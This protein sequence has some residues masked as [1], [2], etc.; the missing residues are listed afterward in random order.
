[1]YQLQH[2]RVSG[3]W[4]NFF[5]VS[6]PYFAVFGTLKQIVIPDDNNA[7]YCRPTLVL[8]RDVPRITNLQG[9]VQRVIVNGEVFEKLMESHSEQLNVAV[10]RGPPC[11]HMPTTHSSSSSSIS[12]SSD[13]L[14]PCQNGGICQPLLANFVCKCQP[15]FIGKRCEKR[16]SFPYFKPFFFINF[17]KKY[18]INFL[19][20]YLLSIVQILTWVVNQLDFVIKT[21]QTLKIQLKNHW[22]S[23]LFLTH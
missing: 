23:L 20:W 4:I 16:N 6:R 13:L 22:N 12:S 10:Y 19:Y 9:A 8:S 21:I 1:M 3:F 14:T 18:F 7:V 2:H 17:L 15:G 5:L 11:G